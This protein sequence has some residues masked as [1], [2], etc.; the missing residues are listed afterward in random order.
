VAH[1]QQAKSLEVRAVTSLVRL[2]QQ[3]G[4]FEVSQRGD[5]AEKLQ[6]AAA[7]RPQLAA[8][9]QWFT[10]GFDTPDLQAAKTLLDELK[11]EP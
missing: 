1:Q 5:K 3:Q 7:A 11:L 8:L 2:W 9:Y 6:K 4:K 10:E